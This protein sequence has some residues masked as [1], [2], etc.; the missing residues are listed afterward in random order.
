MENP[1]APR[2]TAV[3]SLVKQRAVLGEQPP[4]LLQRLVRKELQPHK[5]PDVV[6]IVAVADREHVAVTGCPDSVL[7]LSFD[8][9]H[10]RT[11]VEPER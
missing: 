4:L 3:I 6:M 2:R 10:L 5:P 1:L 7:E 11:G 9:L 8:A